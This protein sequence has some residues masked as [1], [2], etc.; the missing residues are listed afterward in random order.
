MPWEGV[1]MKTIE[2]IHYKN[3][4]KSMPFEIVDLQLFLAT[5]PHKHLSRSFR[6]NF[7]V[8]LYITEGA[9]CHNVDFIDYDF[10]AGDLVI[11][12]RNQVH[13]FHVSTKAKGYILH[14]DEPFFLTGEAMDDGRLRQLFDRPF[15]S[16]ILHLDNSI[17][18]TNRTLM[19]LIYA[20]YIRVE[21]GEGVLLINALFRS[22]VLSLQ[23]ELDKEFNSITGADY[24]HYLAYRKLVE[25]H[26]TQH[27]T[28]E[29]YAQEMLVS[30]KTI[31]KATRAIVDMSAKSFI[32]ER[33]ILEIKRY[34]CQ[35]ELLNYEIADLLGFDEPGNMT[36]LFKGETGLSPKE[37]RE[38]Q[39]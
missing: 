21:G 27:W 16:P 8:M 37:F 19:D 15:R 29:D 34:L 22:F 31:N 35:G 18:T 20:E 17:G 24:R 32:T 23:S 1:C 6:L 10:R 26:F 25:E 39:Q 33:L 3:P 13:H 9:G 38:Q 5:R 14:V 28:V 30:K 2:R 12:N 7:Y 11:L 4:K 36:K